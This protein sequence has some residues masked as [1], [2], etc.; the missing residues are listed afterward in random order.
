ME[1]ISY[2]EKWQAINNHTKIL[3]SHC[4]VWWREQDSMKANNK[5]S[6]GEAERRRRVG[7]CV[8]GWAGLYRNSLHFFCSNLLWPWNCSKKNCLLK[9][10][11]EK[12]HFIT[13]GKKVNRRKHGQESTWTKALDWTVAWHIP[14]SE[15]VITQKSR[16]V[17]K[18]HGKAFGSQNLHHPGGHVINLGL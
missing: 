3:Q 8:W 13:K 15:K 1:F 5:S 11:K 14:G 18:E 4:D 6:R 7:S 17:S 2:E 16:G 12:K 9:R 10:E